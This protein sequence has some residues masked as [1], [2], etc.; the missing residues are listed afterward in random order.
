MRSTLQKILK[1]LE[2]IAND[3]GHELVVNK[4][5]ANVGYALIQVEN[6]Y[7]PTLTVYFNDQVSTISL[8]VT[9]SDSAHVVNSKFTHELCGCYASTRTQGHQITAVFN[10]IKRYLGCS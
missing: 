3:S 8:S 7:T 6:S 4:S 5:F 2:A 10:Y 1:D 9:D